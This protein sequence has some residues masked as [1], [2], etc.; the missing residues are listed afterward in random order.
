MSG[1]NNVPPSFMV[2][3]TLIVLHVRQLTYFIVII[4]IFKIECH[5]AVNPKGDYQDDT[6]DFAVST[7]LSHRAIYK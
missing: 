5:G 3:K 6:G 4:Q 2:V 7:Y 1:V